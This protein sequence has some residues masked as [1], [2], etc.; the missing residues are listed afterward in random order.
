M[1]AGTFGI[2]AVADEGGPVE[3]SVF[4]TA[5]AASRFAIET[6]RSRRSR[7]GIG[8]AVGELSTTDPEPHGRPVDDATALCRAARP[9]QIL[10]G[11]AVK[12]LAGWLDQGQFRSTDAFEPDPRSDEVGAD[13]LVWDDAVPAL[14]RVL[15][16]D[17]AVLIRQGVAAL[18]K[19]EG[20]EVA[21]E[22]GD[23]AS[24]LSQ[25]ADRRPDLVITDVRMPP[26]LTT[27]GLEAAVE[28]RRRHPD[29][30][31]MV[32]SQYVETRYAVDLLGSG[33]RGVGYLLKERVGAV[34]DFT[35]A[36]RR[37]AA[38]G[39]AID[40]EVVGL[41]MG[42]SRRTGGLERLSAREVEILALMAH[43]L[44]NPGIAQR[45]T[46]GIRTVE[47][48]VASIFTKLDLRPGPTEE[49]RVLAVVEYLRR[50]L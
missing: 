44:S 33:A 12:L 20:F 35:A 19:D 47:S 31:V 40:P 49:R 11:R 38:G 7:P 32:L 30:G 15:L 8:I 41:L 5:S 21:G 36:L 37:I 18:L 29:I 2:V 50:R 13:E 1:I 26:T 42:H 23:A 22:A 28:I 3:L 17:D 14:L 24:L 25:V 4:P 45:L 16:A 39:T 34:E 46:V 10:A 43:G 48:H 6:Q 27:E 9:G